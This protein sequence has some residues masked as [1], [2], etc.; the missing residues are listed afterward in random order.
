MPQRKPLR[1]LSNNSS[2]VTR[3]HAARK[4][5][6]TQK[7]ATSRAP[8]TAKRISK[9]IDIL[10][11]PRQPPSLENQYTTRPEIPDTFIP[12]QHYFSPHE[13]QPTL[14]SDPSTPYDVFS[15]FWDDTVFATLV[16][17]TNEYAAKMRGPIPPPGHS[18]LRQWKPATMREMQKFVAQII[19]MGVHGCRSLVEFWRQPAQIG[20]KER[21]SLERFQ[22]IKRYLHIEPVQVEGRKDSEWWRK[23]E[24]LH[25]I[26]KERFQRA[27]KPGSDLA[28]DEMMVRFGGRSK[29]TYRMP[30]KPITQGYRI[31]ALC[32]KGYT[33][34][35]LYTSRA[36]GIQIPDQQHYHGSTH[37]TPTSIA[38]HDLITSLPYH[39]HQFNV[40]M[41]NY[42]S[43]I[44]LF[45]VL[46]ELRIGA[47]GTA[48]QNK[49]AF[50]SDI[51]NDFP[52]LPWNHLS[53]AQVGS[54]SNPILAL[55]WEDSGSVH[56][57]S[58]IHEMHQQKNSI[59]HPHASERTL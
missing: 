11:P 13:A 56:M 14:S 33:W 49:N 35:W 51:H 44:A 50:L 21:L 58:T 18:C 27:L 5:Y 7:R 53:G 12:L 1:T 32:W 36:A 6:A 28:V 25:S 29:H 2:P 37:L 9:A 22:Q 23:L 59:L 3:S 15:E 57:L 55:Q 52:G 4:L 10:D 42:F 47:C 26:L 19:F 31:F 54:I 34:N 20:G 38:I 8:K 16:A 43:N 41:D 45:Q 40:Y 24:P 30:N 17:N 48:R 39:T 46:R